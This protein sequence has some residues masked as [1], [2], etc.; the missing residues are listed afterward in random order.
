MQPELTCVTVVWHTLTLLAQKCKGF[1]AFVMFESAHH[2]NC[3]LTFCHCETTS[4][5]VDVNA[6]P[7]PLGL[8]R[9]AH[10]TGLIMEFINNAAL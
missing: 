4:G 10:H 3:Q 1:T 7:Q 6:S 9:Q 2:R 5:T 8:L